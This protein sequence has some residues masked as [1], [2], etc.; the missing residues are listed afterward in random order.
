[1]DQCRPIFLPLYV[2]R[3]F[4]GPE[5]QSETELNPVKP[6]LNVI[7]A[8]AIIAS[9]LVPIMKVNRIFRASWDHSTIEINSAPAGVYRQGTKSSCRTSLI[10]SRRLALKLS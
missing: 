8:I 2:Q 4:L 9:R 3:P 10:G 7:I 5:G 6:E 1:M